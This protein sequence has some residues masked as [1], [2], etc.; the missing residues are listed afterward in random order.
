MRDDSELKERLLTLFG[1]GPERVTA[2][3]VMSRV[4]D[5]HPVT[6]LKW[7]LR[8]TRV[9]R[10][11]AWAWSSVVVALVVCLVVAVK[12]ESEPSGVRPASSVPDQVDLA[13]TP[14]GWIPVDYGDARLSFPSSW[15]QLGEGS[16]CPSSAPIGQGVLLVPN[17]ENASSCSTS[18]QSSSVLIEPLRTSESIPKA[19]SRS[20]ING[21]AVYRMDVAG[22]IVPDEQTGHA[23]QQWAVPG[24][25]I[26]LSL[27]GSLS[28]RILRTLTYSPRSYVVA[29]GPAPSIPASWKR[30]SFGGV[31]AAVPVSWPSTS[32]PVWSDGCDGPYNGGLDYEQV[33]MSTGSELG[34][35]SCLAVGGLFVPFDG[36]VIDTGEYGPL[37]RTTGLDKCFLIN[38]LSECPVSAD[39]YDVLVL[40]VH[41]P[42]DTKTIAISIGL[43]EAGQVARTILYSIRP[44]TESPPP[45]TT[46]N[47]RIST[48]T[49][50][51]VHNLPR[52]NV[53][54]LPVP[55]NYRC[56]T[57]L[58]SLSPANE[59]AGECVPYSYLV[60][61][62]ASEPD[63]NTACPAGSFMTMGPVECEY[64]TRIV[65]PVPPGPNTCSNP[66]GPCPSSNLPLSPMASV[67][68]WS[69]IE[70][71]TGKCSTD[72]Y[73]GETNGIVTCVPY[74]YLP[75]GT[76]SDPNTNTAC[77]AGSGLKVLNLIG[78]LCTQDAEPHD[79]VAPTR[80]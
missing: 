75:G 33:M 48:N 55:F 47:S 21:I 3:E 50:S 10:G 41:L 54:M 12:V 67:L 79:I 19:T 39:I 24:L 1:P 31:T 20:V 30:I 17:S 40:A 66:G 14:R 70:F 62:T 68:S 53:G 42:G 56:P 5:T 25:G 49:T 44:S 2:D 36:L 58:Y 76:S 7:S 46:T 69:A 32:G 57:G 28:S 43:G 11:V 61:G 37:Y 71:P 38:D 65:T 34:I 52:L 29:P 59:A 73:F 6:S 51:P 4:T 63:N 45:T 72:Y 27:N 35:Q 78:T 23:S 13:V 22:E 74:A 77:P 80:P 15:R 18:D 16:G 9:R 64:R 8:G 26:Q 60:G